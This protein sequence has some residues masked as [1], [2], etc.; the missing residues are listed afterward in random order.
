MIVALA[1]QPDDLGNEV[2]A[3][4][5]VLGGGDGTDGELGGGHHWRFSGFNGSLT[6]CFSCDWEQSHEC[7]HQTHVINAS[8]SSKPAK[9]QTLPL[10]FFL[11]L[12][13]DAL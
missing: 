7:V 5:L 9:G 10:G 4:N 6:S 2:L 8:K 11:I 1:F 13:V 3:G 12:L